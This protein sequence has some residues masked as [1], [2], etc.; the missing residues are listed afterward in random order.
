[1][2]NS[3]PL[4]ESEKPFSFE[5][6]PDG[7]KYYHNEACKVAFG[8]SSKPGTLTVN[9]KKIHEFMYDAVCGIVKVSLPAGE[10]MACF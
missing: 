6:F 1:M 2:K 8:G 5:M 7:I 4:L 3:K 10:G 9:G